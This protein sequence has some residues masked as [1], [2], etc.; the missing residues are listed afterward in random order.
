MARSFSM[1]R[2]EFAL[3]GPVRRD[4]GFPLPFQD[5][6]VV[7]GPWAGD[8]IRP[9][10]TIAVSRAAGKI[11]DH[12]HAQ[13]FGQQYGLAAD[14]LIVLRALL[15]R[16]QRVAV[17]AQRADAEAA[18]RQ[19]VFEFGQLGGIVQHGQLAVRIARIITG[20]EF[21]R[22]DMD[23]LELLEDI[24]QGKLR[25]QGGENADS[26]VGLLLGLNMPPSRI[27]EAALGRRGQSGLNR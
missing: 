16:V 3:S 15:I 2:G 22:I 12:R 6:K 9:L 20:S 11:D 4:F 5:F 19:F 26:H 14:R 7:R 23:A 27:A 13:F 24:V 1:V 21:D 17:A 18:I 8:P 25:Q 10:G